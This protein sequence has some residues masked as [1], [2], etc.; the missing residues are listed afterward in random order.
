MIGR[1]VSDVY[2][3]TADLRNEPLWD[4][5]IDQVVD[6]IDMELRPGRGFAARFSPFLGETTGT[7]TV[8]DVVPEERLVLAAQFAGLTSTI[9]YRYAAEG[10]ATRFTREVTVT[11]EGLVRLLTPLVS[12]RVTRS[13][14]R[15]VVTLKRVLEES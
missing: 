14:R 2:A 4:H 12:L 15:D 3:F 10:S 1:P 8:A 9:T 7:L 6:E 13:N 11:A 5:D